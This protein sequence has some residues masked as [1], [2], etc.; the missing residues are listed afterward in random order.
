MA[1]LTT[2]TLAL[3]VWAVLWPSLP[4]DVAVTR[5]LQAHPFPGAHEAA[6]LVNMLGYAPGAVTLSVALASALA[7]RGYERRATVVVLALPLRLVPSLVKA[8][9]AR[10]RPA[11]DLVDVLESPPDPGFPSGHAFGAVLFFGLVWWLA[12]VLAPRRIARHALRALAVG[13]ILVTG[14]SRVLVGAHWPSDVLGG[15]LWGLLTLLPLVWLAPVG[16]ERATPR[17]QGEATGE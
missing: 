16:G 9:V 12:P 5:W 8:L 13:L 11:P 2:T 4:G 17:A 3:S 1:A 15:Y 14:Y 7:W 10:P 6:W